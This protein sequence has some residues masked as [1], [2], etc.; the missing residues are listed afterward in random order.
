MRK[1][2]LM[3]NTPNL[4]LVLTPE[5]NDA[6]MDFKTWRQVINGESEDSNAQKIDK[7]FGNVQLKTNIVLSTDTEAALELVNNSET[8]YSEI[9][10]LTITLPESISDNFISSVIFT[11][12]TTP[13]TVSIPTDIYC[14]GINCANGSF[15]PTANKRYT[16]I[17]DYDGQFKNGTVKATPIAVEEPDPDPVEEPTE[18]PIPEEDV[19]TSEET[20]IPASGEE[21]TETENTTTENSTADEPSTDTSDAVESDSGSES[22]KQ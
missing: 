18:D 19:T 3:G 17:F 22:V 1:D 4:N 9:S 15:S 2:D 14:Q 6:A 10:L 11:S 20:D 5:N 21:Q 12:G 7:A 8:R 16:I 13:P